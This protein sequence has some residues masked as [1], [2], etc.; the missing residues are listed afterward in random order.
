MGRE[1]AKQLLQVVI[2]ASCRRADGQVG[3][4]IEGAT[5]VAGARSTKSHYKG[6]HGGGN[7]PI[8]HLNISF[9]YI[10]LFARRD[11]RES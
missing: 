9:T 10:A 5:A 6:R 4:G 11:V 8:P 1:K 7:T 2:G 3:L